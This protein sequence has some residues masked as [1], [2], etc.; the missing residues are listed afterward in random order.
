[1]VIRQAG[2]WGVLWELKIKSCHSGARVE[3]RN[4]SQVSLMRKCVY[5]K[6]STI[7]LRSKLKKKKK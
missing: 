3:R 1:M 4:E 7:E 2:V 6:A 5:S